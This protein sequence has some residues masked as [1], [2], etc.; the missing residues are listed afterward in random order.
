MSSI[1]STLLG[2]FGGG[3]VIGGAAVKLLLDDT[4]YGRSLTAAET[5]TRASTSR[6]AGSAQGMSQAGVAA[7]AV[8]G[9]AAIAF[10][11]DAVRSAIEAEQVLAQLRNV[12]GDTSAFEAQATALQRLT[13]FQDESIL[14]ADA[15]L[16]RFELTEEQ[17]RQA[18]PT[19]LDFARATG[20]DV[21]AAA[22]AVG[23]A[24]LGNTRALK[25]V[26]IDYTRT[27]DAA[28]DFRNI[29]G[30]L[31]DRVSG[32]AA[33]FGKTTA[34]QLAILTAEF[35]EAKEEIGREFLPIILEVA[36]ILVD[37]AHVVGDVV[38]AALQSSVDALR[39]FIE[40]L[41]AVDDLVT[42]ISGSTEDA[43]VG[44][45]LLASAL[46]GI[47]GPTLGL[48]SDF[49]EY[50]RGLDEVKAKQEELAR[51]AFGTFFTDTEENLRGV[52]IPLWERYTG[53]VESAA[54]RQ[55]DAVKE[56]KDDVIGDLRSTFGT[57]EGFQSRFT[58]TARAFQRDA[59]QMARESRQ[60]TRDL[61]KLKDEDLGAG[62]E[63]A[64]LRE[65]PAAVHAYVTSNEQGQADIRAALRSTQTELQK[66]ERL[67]RD[68]VDGTDALKGALDG[69]DGTRVGI[70]VDVNIT[71]IREGPGS[72]AVQDAVA[73]ALASAARR[74][75]IN[76]GRR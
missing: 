34:G 67:I 30:L 73:D 53:K 40:S 69:L 56:L 64:L 19:V 74:E 38:P 9:A 42:Q 61:R 10:A 36:P 20:R 1:A 60:F 18:I 59:S 22:S 14:S 6:I 54:D 43:S 26:G 12:V 27:G 63:E 35:D 2:G 50:Q 24:L 32:S 70:T 62:I 52:L 72:S 71:G 16:A 76:G 65:G 31:Q 51:E 49:G 55:S 48:L 3:G 25:D 7:F 37:L 13:G 57:I 17:V 47:R 5:K 39:P 45:D 46:D 29:L 15:L 66:Q 41:S 21:P 23:K 8:L 4:Q 58:T 44:S 11:V 33:D 68:M 75:R 28:T